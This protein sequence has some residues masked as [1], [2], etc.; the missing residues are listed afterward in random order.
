MP[1]PA[2]A[3]RLGTRRASTEQAVPPQAS[4][5]LP[6]LLAAFCGRLTPIVAPC[7]VQPRCAESCTG[8]CAELC[9]WVDDS[10]AGTARH[11]PAAPDYHAGGHAKAG[12]MTL[13]DALCT[14]IH[15]NNG[16]KDKRGS[17]RSRTPEAHESTEGLIHQNVQIPTTNSGPML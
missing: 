11:G 13:C 17:L 9:G 14:C 1:K 5:R 4:L 16:M 7:N 15:Q 6:F 12:E 2:S 10:F 3:T 8:V